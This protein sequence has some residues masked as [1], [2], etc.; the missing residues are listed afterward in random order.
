MERVIGSTITVSSGEETDYVLVVKDVSIC[1]SIAGIPLI[2]VNIQEK[3]GGDEIRK[4]AI[5]QID[6]GGAEGN[7]LQ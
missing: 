5:L 6:F 7:P 3:V 4:G 1:F 2:G